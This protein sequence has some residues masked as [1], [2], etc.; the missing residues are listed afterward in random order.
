MLIVIRGGV[1]WRA[2]TIVLAVL[3]L[4]VATPL[5]A[6]SPG[7]LIFE[8]DFDARSLNTTYWNPF[9]TDDSAEGW[10]WSTE[11]GQPSESSAISGPYGFNLDYD[12]PSFVRTGS[13]LTL[14]ARAG[15][16]AEGYRWTGA[17]IS[18]YP[19]D[20]FVSTQGFTFRDA[21]VEVRA[22]LPYTGNGSWPAIWFLAGPGGNGAE[23]DLHEGG[24]LDGSVNPDR[25]F[26]C[27]LHSAGNVQYLIDTGFNLSA[28]YHTYGMAYEQGEYVKMY[29]DGRLMCSYT[30]NIPEGPY[31]IILNNSVASKGTDSWHSQVDSSTPS[32]NEMSVAYVKVYELI[33]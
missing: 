33:R 30:A 16:T 10:P 32:P 1:R 8:D 15:T 17:V 5:G 9:I 21:F 14:A 4:S 22:K 26:A 25:V 3:F 31:F 6:Q 29:L 27:N 2:V 13:G 28:A 7:R 11:N 12:Q 20:N 18:S 24:F 19:D 23:I